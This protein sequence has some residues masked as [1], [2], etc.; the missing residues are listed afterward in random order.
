MRRAGRP[1]LRGAQP[2]P[3]QV[4]VRGRF[5]ARSPLRRAREAFIPKSARLNLQGYVLRMADIANDPRIDPR[6]KTLLGAFPSPGGL[7]DAE[8]REQ[9]LAEANSEQAMA[10]RTMITALLN[11]ADTEEIASS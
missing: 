2:A 10:Q 11:S 8:S 5:R 7:G 9:L 3:D 6:I 4:G 1:R